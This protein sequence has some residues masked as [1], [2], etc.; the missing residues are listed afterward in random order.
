MRDKHKNPPTGG[1]FVSRTLLILPISIPASALLAQPALASSGGHGLDGASLGVIWAVPFVGILLSIALLPLLAPQFWHRHFGKVAAAWALAFVL[2]F[3]LLNGE[4][5]VEPLAETVLLDY[6]PFVILLTALFTIAGGILVTGNLHGS[7]KTNLALLAIGTLLASA[8]GTTGASMVMIRPLLRAND[9]RRHNVHVVVFFIFLVSNIG[10][11]L[12]PLGDPPLFLGYL[13]G[14]GFF[15]TLLH[16][17]KETGFAAVVLLA[18]FYAID[19]RLYRNDADFRGRFD[20][21]PDTGRV[22]VEGRLNIALL[23]VVVGAVLLSG[24]WKPAIGFPLFGVEVELQNLARDLILIA[25][26]LASLSLTPKGVR[27]RNGFE[28]GPILEVAKLFAGIF[29]TI[30]PVLAML[31][32]AH[33]GAFAPLVGL[34]T[35]ADG[36]PVNAMYFW[37]TGLL[38]SFLDNAPTYLVFFNLAGGD[39]VHL[40]GEM[41]TTLVAISAGAVFMGANSYIGNAPNFMVKSIAEGAGVKMPS[42]FGYMAWSVGILV[43]LFLVMTLVFFV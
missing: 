36:A 29:V 14:V 1:K 41:A 31:R 27:H 37:A 5:V 43:P 15:W 20:P 28:W 40:M 35:T 6:L 42:F 34:V 19:H 10:G 39:P 23:M 11:S 17:L 25:A 32:A 7:P 9:G 30:I 21:T 38:S 4:A 2:P 22:G 24:S 26:A 18:L 13:R 3:T 8:V 33:E 16:M 12:T